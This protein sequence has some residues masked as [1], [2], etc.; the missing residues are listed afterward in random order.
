MNDPRLERLAD[1]LI[2]HSTR[3]SAGELVLIECFDLPEPTLPCILVRKAVERDAIPLV[4]VK[5]NRILRELWKHGSPKQ[6]KL[7]GTLEASRMKQVQAYIGIR[8]ADNVS[9]M[10][11]VPTD[12]MKLYEAHI[13]DPVHLKIRVAKTKW[14]VLRYP[15]PSMAQLANMSTNAFEDYFFRVCTVDYAAMA[16]AQKPLEKLMKRTDR[17]KITGP[18]T[19]LDFSIKGIGVVPC[20][21]E[22]NIPDGE[23]FS[24]PVRDSL[25]GVITF[26]TP[27]VYRG[28]NF[29][30]IRFEFEAGKIVD[31]TCPGNSKQLN[32]I[33]DTDRGAR[34]VGEWSIGCNPQVLF[35]MRDILFD[36][37]IAGS[38]HLT[39]G[40]AY[41]EADNGNRSKIHWDLVLIQR[42]DYGGGEI[43]FDGKLIR[44]DG[45]FTL[46]ELKPLDADSGPAAP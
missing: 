23:V 43:H 8:A 22:R 46:P 16:K 35:P 26:N 15:T 12:K 3:L 38:I 21:G 45:R 7:I 27:T 31:A 5:N 39:P 30:N 34:Y 33:L 14:V 19:D 10:S 18:G 36:E 29:E 44:K 17:V 37:K 6:L 41:D 4:S 9:E 25:N 42:P 40:N 13:W 32:E 28:V 2:D 11:D 24:A 1:V 20:N